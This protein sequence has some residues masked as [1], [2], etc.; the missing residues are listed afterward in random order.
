MPLGTSASH[1][2][3]PVMTIIEYLEWQADLCRRIA[4]ACLDVATA[5]S[6]RQM[7][8][9]HEQRAEAEIERQL[10]GRELSAESP[11]RKRFN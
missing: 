3:L 1:P 2:A 9:L 10:S 4:A 6:L 7:A 11:E 5:N 8:A